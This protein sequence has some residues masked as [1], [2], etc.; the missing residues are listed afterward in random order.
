MR[1]LEKAFLG[2]IVISRLSCSRLLLV[3]ASIAAAAM[4]G[5]LACAQSFQEYAYPNPYR[6]GEAFGHLPKGRMWGSTSAVTLDAQGHIWVG[7]RCGKNSC[8]GSDLDSILEFDSSGKL[9]KSFGGGLLAVPHSIYF[10]K[11]GNIWVTDSGEL[12]APG[13]PAPDPATAAKETEGHV[14]IKFSPEGKILMTLGKPGVSAEGPDTFREP[15]AVVE[16]AN[17]DLFVSDGH[18]PHKGSARIVKFTKDGKFIKQWGGLGSAPGQFDVPHALAL[19]SSGRLFVADR[20]D[21]RIQIFDQ[22]GTFLEAWTQFGSP[23]G[24]FI[25]RN[26]VMYVSD[27]QAEWTDPKAD[28]YNPGFEHGVHV[29]NARDGRVTAFIPMPVPPNGD[30]APEGIAADVMGNIYIAETIVRGVWK[31]TKK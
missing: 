12:R 16:G 22:D 10:D 8:T 13:A 17:G 21:K 24:I 31:Y 11:A 20:A 15:N 27:S 26:D 23:S 4:C 29:G 3:A 25:D 5:G 9:L 1:R 28:R 2:G 7:E 30:N 6:A 18:V 14:A 19:D